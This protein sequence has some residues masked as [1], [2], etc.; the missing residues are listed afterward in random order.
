MR[1]IAKIPAEGATIDNQFV[2]GRAIGRGGVGIVFEATQLGLHRKVAVKMLLPSAM[3][4]E[5]VVERFQREARLASSLRHPH[6]VAIY[7]FGVYGAEDAVQGLP[8]IAMEYLDG[9][10]LDAY[11]R[12]RGK[13]PEREVIELLTQILGSLAEA[14]DK[15]VIHRDLKP[16]NLFLVGTADVP[17]VKVLDFGIAKAVSGQWGSLSRKLTATGMLCG[18]PEYMAPEQATGEAIITP[19]LDVYAVGCIAF[20]LLT[21]HPP[22]VGR[23]PLTVALKHLSEP[24]P[25][26]EDD[27]ISPRLKALVRRALAKEPGE[28]FS[29]ATALLSALTEVSDDAPVLDVAPQLTAEFPIEGLPSPLDPHEASTERQATDQWRGSAIHELRARINSGEHIRPPED[30]WVHT[31]PD[32]PRVEPAPGA[33]AASGIALT[34]KLDHIEAHLADLRED[35]PDTIAETP[36]YVEKTAETDAR[37]AGTHRTLAVAIVIGVLAFFIFVAAGLGAVWILASLGAP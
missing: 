37:V 26:L 23:S 8:Y 7:S 21:G 13:L 35:G 25:D 29:D 12:R 33:D 1:T 18:T 15:G 24:I 34:V 6:S 19:A 36:G 14:H 27:E 3:G 10:T 4:V 9:E 11:V 16:E 31:V 20:T 30:R 32:L 2:L 17:V 5:G 22:F 28:R